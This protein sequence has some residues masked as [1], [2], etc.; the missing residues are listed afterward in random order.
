MSNKKNVVILGAT[1]SI[2]K[3]SLDIIR[4]HSGKLRVVGLSV[5]GNIKDLMSQ[6]EEFKPAYVAV[7]NEAKAQELKTLCGRKVRVLSS[8]DG[9]CRLACLKDVDIVV[10]AIVGSDAVLPVL[11][12]ID[13]KKTI[14]LANKESLV[15]AGDIVM[16]RARKNKVQIIP[17]DSEQSAIFQCLEGYS[18]DAVEKVYLTASGGPLI[19]CSL[20]QLKKVTQAKVLAHPRWKM[21]R[22]ITVDSATLM[23]KGLEVIEAQKLFNLKL[24]KVSVLVH[25]QAL[26][27]SLVEFVDGS[28]IAQMGITD[29]RLPIQYALTYPKRWP[30]A[31]LRLNLFECPDLT[32]EKPSYDKFPCLGLAFEAARLGGTAPCVLNAVN[33]VAVEAFLKGLLA[34]VDIPKIIEKILSKKDL[35]CQNPTLED[36]FEA[37]KNA[38]L[39]ALSQIERYQ[40]KGF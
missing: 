23:N 26:I 17:I 7:R 39:R 34:F 18:P 15:V 11:S 5:N 31:R 10:V 4:Q 8:L 40:K 13:G 16:R 24:E 22:K 35:F 2:G 25:R 36:I 37:D 21:G 1:G 20:S 30:N 14:A 33:E 19:D 6:I 9:V 38:R 27:H 28:I 3:S 29:M 12:A 32:F